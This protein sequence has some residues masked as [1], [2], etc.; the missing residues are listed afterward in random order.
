[1]FFRRPFCIGGLFFFLLTRVHQ[2]SQ[3]GC[4]QCAEDDG[5]GNGNRDLY[6]V[7]NQHLDTDKAQYESQAVFEEDKAFGKIR[8]Q[9]VHG[10]QTQ[11]G[12]NVGG[13]DDE[14]VGGDGKNSGNAVHGEDDVAQFDHNQYQ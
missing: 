10:T 12:K 13:K 14:R 3:D 9:K 11:D 8:Q 6:P 5:Q 4:A 2:R 1:M 7:H